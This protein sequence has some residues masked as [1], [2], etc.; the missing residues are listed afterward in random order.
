MLIFLGIEPVQAALLRGQR[1]CV[2]QP[3]HRLA[4]IARRIRRI[5]SI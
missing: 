1:A 3:L 4:L 5:E 2:V